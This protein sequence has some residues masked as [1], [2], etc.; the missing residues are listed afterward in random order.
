MPTIIYGAGP[1]VTRR[2]EQLRKFYKAQR[3]IDGWDGV[4]PLADGDLAITSVA[5]PYGQAGDVIN[6]YDAK[7]KLEAAGLLT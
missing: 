5:P 7:A 6:F 1:L 3:V 2:A 4:K